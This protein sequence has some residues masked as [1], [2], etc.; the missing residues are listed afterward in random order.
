M[1]RTQAELSVSVASL[2]T[3]APASGFDPSDLRLRLIDVWL[4]TVAEFR[5]SSQR[6][7]S[8]AHNEEPV[9]RRCRRPSVLPT[10][11]HELRLHVSLAL[12]AARVTP[13]IAIDP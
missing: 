4:D 9:P 5:R 8:F 2:A 1:G 3:S 12:S 6:Q 11:L 7:R 13:R 10:V